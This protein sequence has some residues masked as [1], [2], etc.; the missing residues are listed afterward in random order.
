MKRTTI[1]TY[2]RDCHAPIKEGTEIHADDL[3]EY[4]VCI[5]CTAS[6][7]HEEEA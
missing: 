7:D 2:C 5:V 1:E 3:G 4:V 6:Q